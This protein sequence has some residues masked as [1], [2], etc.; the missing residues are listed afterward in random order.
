M[1]KEWNVRRLVGVAVA[2]LLSLVAISLFVHSV[3]VRQKY[4]AEGRVYLNPG[5]NDWDPLFVQKQIQTISNILSATDDRLKLA[6]A[7]NTHESSFQL[8]N[9]GQ[10]RSTCLFYVNYS[11]TESNVVQNVASNAAAMIVELYSTNKANWKVA[12]IDAGCY[13]PRSL[14]RRML[15]EIEYMFK[16]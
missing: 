2:T 6:A 11:G 5:T 9:V 4:F 12:Y 7:C 14:W 16:R 3:N 10:V 1:N 13:T 15:D 8:K